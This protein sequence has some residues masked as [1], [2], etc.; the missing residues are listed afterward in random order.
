MMQR[1]I[2]DKPDAYETQLR[3]A[4][5]PP[6]SVTGWQC[7]SC[8]VETRCGRRAVLA[9]RF[10]SRRVGRH[11][12]RHAN[13]ADATSRRARARRARNRGA[14]RPGNLRLEGNP[15][16]RTRID[17]APFRRSARPGKRKRSPRGPRCA[18]L[19]KRQFS[20]C[21]RVVAFSCDMMVSTGARWSGRGLSSLRLGVRL[22]SPPARAYGIV[23]VD[24]T[25]PTRTNVRK[26]DS[27]DSGGRLYSLGQESG[28]S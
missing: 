18:L 6:Q 10:P 17:H 28:I 24:L 14:R 25:G 19:T 13:A 11:D 27:R 12:I 2:S 26:D 22:P 9:F 8:G 5:T 21:A 7:P 1:E 15:R 16:L 20:G 4:K 23:A 3:G